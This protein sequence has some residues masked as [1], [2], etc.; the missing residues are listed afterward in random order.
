[1]LL[2][3]DIGTS[4]VAA[5]VCDTRGRL[6]ARAARLH[7]ADRPAAPGRSEQDVEALLAVAEDTVRDLP[8]KLRRGI[9]AVGVT[10]QMHGVLMADAEGRAAAPLVTWQDGRC[11]EDPAFLETLRE[12][13]GYALRTGYG[14]ATLTWLQAH[15]ALPD[16]AASAATIHD[17]LSAR[18]VGCTRPVTDPTDAAGW[19]LFDRASREWDL[20]AV[21]GAGFASSL[22]PAVVDSGRCIGRLTGDMAAALGLPGGVPVAA[23]IGDNQASLLA[24][25]DYPQTEAALT[26]GTGGQLSVVLP[27][28]AAVPD[29]ATCEA[30][31]FPGGRTALVAASLCGGSAWAWLAE[32]VG[33]WL[34]E[35]DRE[36]LA[37]DALYARLNALGQAAPDGPT[38][39]PHFL[40]ERHA[41]GLTGA[42][43]GLTPD[44]LSLGTLARALARGIV[45]NLRDMLPAGALRGR[46][47]LVGSGNALRRNALL[48]DMAEQVFGLPLALSEG[49]EEA[50]RGAALNAAPLAADA[51]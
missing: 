40:G 26:L 23:A 9:A 13:T 49:A 11:G 34:R 46:Q 21:Q 48:R 41:P 31:P 7:A 22:L 24:T 5:V 39:H 35:L 27:A 44:A 4:K 47:R 3:I 25:L 33:S 29:C 14:C 18:L 2:G 1:M 16:R 8:D 28:T 15:G 10:G 36:A 32:T 20:S 38:V 19:G 50:A 12:R 37:P 6:L 30:R 51:P 42:I 17:L 45:A 43:D